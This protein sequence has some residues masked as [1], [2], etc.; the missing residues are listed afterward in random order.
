MT[1]TPTAADQADAKP[2]ADAPRELPRGYWEA[3]DGSLVPTSKVSDIDKARD[4]VVRG[5]VA[6]ALVINGELTK[7][8]AE[9][10]G[11]INTFVDQTAK[12]YGVTV[13]GAAGKGNVTLTTFDGRMKVERKI[14]DRITYDERLQVAKAAIDEF[15]GREMKGSN[16]NIRA[17]VNQY[18][19]V[20]K[21][22]RVSVAEITK[23]RQIDI[24]HPDWHKAMALVTASM[25]IS[26][27]AVYVRCY[28]RDDTT[29]RY[30][31]ISLDAASV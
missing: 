22:G 13:R 29:G 23:L 1:Q 14:A 26:P 2:E 31:P 20:D 24:D 10:L 28:R 4:K 3:A 9:A 17:I 16:A 5:L 30:E 8:K 19:K 12:Q 18:F 27:S 15:L 21:L 25:H 6:E 11:A 7:F